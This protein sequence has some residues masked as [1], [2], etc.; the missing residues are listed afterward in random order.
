MMQPENLTRLITKLENLVEDL[1][2]IRDGAGLTAADLEGAPVLEHW[3]RVSRPVWA[4]HGDV[5]D[6]PRLGTR[7][8]VV[9]SELYLLDPMG[10][11]AR[12]LSR[13]YRLGRPARPY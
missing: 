10:G 7:P 6:H 12:T 11:W 2:A 4:L 3:T 9:T 13:R 8:D 5:V 1:R